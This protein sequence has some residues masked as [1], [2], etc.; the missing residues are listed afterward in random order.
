MAVKRLSRSTLSG[1]ASGV[2]TPDYQPHRHSPGIVHLGLG[3]FHR[4]HQAVYTDSAIGDSG[5]NWRIIGVSLCRR[6]VSC[7]LNPQDGLYSVAVTSPAGWAYR[8]VGSISGVLFAPDSPAQVVSLMSSPSIHVVTVTVTEKGYCLDAVAKP[9]SAAETAN[10]AG[11]TDPDKP[12]S[13]LGF[14]V[15]VMEAR[16]RTGTPPFT[17]VSCDNL[18][19]NGRLLKSLVVEQAGLRNPQLAAWIDRNAAFPA[20]MVDRIVPATSESDLAR[21][22]ATLGVADHGHVVTESFSQ[23]VVED[24]FSGP[25]PAWERVGVQLVS[26]LEPFELVKLRMLNAAHS[27]IAYLG[28]LRGFEFVHEAMRDTAM[29]RLIEYLLQHEIIPTLT[30][31][32][33]IDLTTYRVELINRL[34]NPALKHRTDQIAM[35][36]SKKLPQRLLGTIRDRLAVN[37][38]IEGLSLSVSGWIR[39]VYG[40]NEQGV[41]MCVQDPMAEHLGALT[42]GLFDEPENALR[43]VL[44]VTEIFGDDLPRNPEFIDALRGALLDFQ[45]FG[46]KKTV[47]QRVAKFESRF[48]ELIVR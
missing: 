17:V 13:A 12:W 28:C 19:H 4:A 1:V 29:R 34:S 47:G 40:R 9:S 11:E 36:G 30:P 31:P 32:K 46:V 42:A 21:A 45:K 24:C 33:G 25:R 10:V 18:L 22:A 23:W 38:P 26:D 6:T 15:A 20:T 8:I 41:T 5:G 35:D 2:V 27:T 44:A 16:R 7:Q 14:L 3:A 39:Y 37:A 48:G 43:R